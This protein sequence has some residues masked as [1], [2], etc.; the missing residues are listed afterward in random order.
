[1]KTAAIIQAR[2]GSTRLP[3][4][5]LRDIAGETMLARVVSRVRR[6]SLLD[7]IIIATTT[8]LADSAIV[9]ECERLGVACFQGSEADVLDRYYQAALA[10]DVDTVV[11]ITSDCPLIEPVIIDQVITTFYETE[12]D[13]AS[14]SLSR[15]FPRGLDTEVFKNSVLKQNWQAATELYQRSHVTP[16]IYQNPDLFRLVEVTSNTDYSQHRWTVDTLADW[17]LVEAIYAH[18]APQTDFDWQ[19]ILHL[20]QQQPHLQTINVDIEQKAIQK[21]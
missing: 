7:Q 10:F 2:M 21:G 12:A 13:Y 18:F 5:A 14:N 11:R 4:K 8:E 3:G 16:Y 9:A 19:D 6:T 20:L 1:M 15:T 17:Q